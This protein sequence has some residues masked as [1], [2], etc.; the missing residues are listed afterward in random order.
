MNRTAAPLA[1]GTIETLG[2]P[3]LPRST[4][5]TR[6]RAAPAG[7]GGAATEKRYSPF[8]L[9]QSRCVR[10]HALNASEALFVRCAHSACRPATV[11]SVER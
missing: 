5:R 7:F 1:V 10:M 11:A 4:T 2:A 9:S 8:T 6:N 3:T